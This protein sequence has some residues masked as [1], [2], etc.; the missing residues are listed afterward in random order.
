MPLAV[1]ELELDVAP[2][3]PLDALAV[4]C[5]PP[6][7]FEPLGVEPQAA[8]ASASP[9]RSPFSRTQKVVSFIIAL[10]LHRLNCLLFLPYRPAAY[11]PRTSA[12]PA[13]IEAVRR[14]WSPL[15]FR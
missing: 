7:V 8:H 12:V 2:P 10:L 4:V 6:S 14:P 9:P 11:M 15:A 13:N 3:A 1:L 5:P